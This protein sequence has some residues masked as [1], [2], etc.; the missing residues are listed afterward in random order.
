MDLSAT[1]ATHAKNECTHG[2]VEYFQINPSNVINVEYI[3][4]SQC[5]M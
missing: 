3:V 4:S 1:W 2:S 5:L